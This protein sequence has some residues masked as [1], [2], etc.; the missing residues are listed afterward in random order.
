MG[1][2]VS[3]KRK[4]LRIQSPVTLQS[5]SCLTMTFRNVNMISSVLEMSPSY[6][7]LVDIFHDHTVSDTEAARRKKSKPATTYLQIR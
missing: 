7:I 1:A 6:L 3:R 4:G 5:D 2:D